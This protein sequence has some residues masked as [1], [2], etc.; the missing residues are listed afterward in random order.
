[1][2]QAYSKAEIQ[3][4]PTR[5]RAYAIIN[6]HYPHLQCLVRASNAL[7]TQQ[8]LCMYYLSLCSQHHQDIVSLF[9]LFYGGR[10]IG[11]DVK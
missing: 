5:A 8:V 2:G 9:F 1:M 7:G 3:V 10:N 11:N 6:I 4:M